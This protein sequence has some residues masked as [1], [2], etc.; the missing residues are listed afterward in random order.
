[1]YEAVDH[2]EAETRTF[3]NPFGRIEWV[4][5]ALGGFGCHAGSVVTNGYANIIADR[6]LIRMTIRETLVESYILALNG[7]PAA[8]RHGV[9]P[10][11]R[12]I[13]DGIFEFALIDLNGPQVGRR[14]QINFYCF[15]Q[16][17]P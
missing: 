16:Q 11:K 8:V 9:A 10:V 14:L 17:R 6:D 2:A 5:G 1:M 15:A 13:H 4:E 7:Q 12:Q 3:A